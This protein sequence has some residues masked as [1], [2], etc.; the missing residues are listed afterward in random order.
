M[1]NMGCI[2]AV[3]LFDTEAEYTAEI[4]R[5]RTAITRITLIGAE[6]ENQSGGSS[7]KM[8]EAELAQLEKYV[9]KLRGQLAVMQGKTQSF[10]QTPSW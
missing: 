7:R 9:S 5:V 10:T 4:A 2:M 3:Y 8:R 1:S 6:N